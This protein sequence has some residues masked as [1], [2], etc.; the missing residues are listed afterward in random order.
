[1]S[2]ESVAFKNVYFKL[3]STKIARIWNSWCYRLVVERI[4][5]I[6]VYSEVEKDQM[7]LTNSVFLAVMITGI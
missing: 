1:M 4:W 5:H 6:L 3:K 7:S 2:A